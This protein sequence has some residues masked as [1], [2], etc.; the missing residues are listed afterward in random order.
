MNVPHHR[1][2]ALR[3]AFTLIE[4]LV[5]IAIIA[6]L[7]SILL[8]SLGNARKTAWTVMCQSNLR[9]LGIAT[10]LY[11]DEQK[12]P[13]FMDLHLWDNPNIP[14]DQRTSITEFYHVG[15]VDTL[16]SYLGDAGNKPFECPAAKGLSSVR[17]PANIALLQGGQRVF[18]LP[19]PNLGGQQPN[20]KWT[21]YW[22]NDSVTPL[23]YPIGGPNRPPWG[24]SAQRIRLIRNPQWVVWAMDALDEFPR[25]EGK[26]NTGRQNTGKD[27]LLF[28]DHAVRLLSYA[29]YQD[30]P[31]PMGAPAPFYNW[32]HLYPR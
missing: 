3:R 11:L 26:G 25:H 8:P 13:V 24:V 31:D 16:Q 29:D 12:D 21:E 14:M 9:Q 6:M 17:D 7:I 4:L 27:N 19:Y 10:Q 20:T 23:V 28:G 2:G 30:T 15:V 18:T 1:P 5:V 32:G 22:F